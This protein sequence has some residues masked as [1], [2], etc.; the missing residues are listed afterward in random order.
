LLAGRLTL[1]VVCLV[2]DT[3]EGVV[4]LVVALVMRGSFKKRCIQFIPLIFKN[5]R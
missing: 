2:K 5:Q 3:L 1:V 4:L